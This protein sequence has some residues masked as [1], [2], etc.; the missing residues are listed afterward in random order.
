M[1]LCRTKK[2]R[3]TKCRTGMK[4]VSKSR[5]RKRRGTR[6]Y[7]QG[8]KVF[9]GFGNL[10][11]GMDAFLPPLVGGGTTL[12]TAL[13]LRAFVDPQV[14]GA[15]DMPEM[16]SDGT[17]P[18]VHWAFEYAGVIGAGAGVL[19][20]AILGPF[21]GW[22]SAVA[23]GLT[24]LL[25]GM[26]AQF[27]NKV[28]P[29]KRDDQMIRSQFAWRGLGNPM[30]LLAPQVWGGG[31]PVAGRVSAG[32]NGFGNPYGLIGAGQAAGLNLQGGQSARTP[33]IPGRG[34]MSMPP[35]VLNQIYTP[36]FGG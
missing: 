2:G 12:G 31:G 13:L 16:E 30:G 9:S 8:M 11:I 34:M 36:A 28:V 33:V 6:G 18:K 32:L 22:G 26:T 20:S 4:R 15:N 21:Q 10:D 23:G 27:Y 14:K 19:T 25:A 1:A 24:A 35:H 5:R 29:E 17:T 7:G 3:F